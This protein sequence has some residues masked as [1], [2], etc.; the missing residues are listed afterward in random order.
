MVHLLLDYAGVPCGHQVLGYLALGEGLLHDLEGNFLAVLAYCP[1]MDAQ[2]LVLL[3]LD[4]DGCQVGSQVEPLFHDQV[5]HQ[6]VLERELQ[7]GF[8]GVLLCHNHLQLVVGVL[9]ILAA[10]EALSFQN[11]V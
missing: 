1:L 7:V 6:P 10:D 5:S 9:E 4:L 11:Q 3:A 8:Q 2:Q